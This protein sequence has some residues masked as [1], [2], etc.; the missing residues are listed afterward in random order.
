MK[1]WLKG[2]LIGLVVY[3]VASILLD[4]IK[5][6]YLG[7]PAVILSKLFLSLCIHSTGCSGE[8]CLGAGIYCGLII[9]Y[10]TLI[11]LGFLIGALIGFIIQKIKSK[12]ESL[13]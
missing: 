7:S 4:A 2:G 6:R 3:P 10:P 13:K 11:I 1:T 12:K 8:G 5:F 9:G